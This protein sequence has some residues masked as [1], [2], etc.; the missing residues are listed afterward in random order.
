VTII[1]IDDDPGARAANARA[2]AKAGYS[3]HSGTTARAAID[4]ARNVFDLVLVLLDINLPGASGFDALRLLKEH[5][6]LR[7]VPVL[8]I[9]AAADRAKDEEAKRLGAVGLLTYPLSDTELVTAVQSAIGPEE[10][11]S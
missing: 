11:A 4:L 9:S 8:M 6:I 2:L 7:G 10:L 5:P 3:V 1:L